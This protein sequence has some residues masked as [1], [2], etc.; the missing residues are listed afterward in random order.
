MK[1]QRGC[2]LF[3]H[4]TQR[5]PDHPTD[6]QCARTMKPQTARTLV[7]LRANPAGITPAMAREYGC[8]DRLAARIS[9]L[10]HLFGHDITSKRTV[11]PTRG[12]GTA[13]VALYQLHEQPEQMRWTA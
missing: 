12:G 10:R 13:Y 5:G 6:C 7:L 3:T 8:G 4:P 11:V 1:H 2:P 9:E